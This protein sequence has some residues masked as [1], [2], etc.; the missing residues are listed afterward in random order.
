MLTGGAIHNAVNVP[1]LDPE[2][3]EKLRPH[4][5]LGERL[6]RIHGQLSEGEPLRRVTVEYRARSPPPPRRP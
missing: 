4:L 2:A 3:Y 6:G 1:S 5:E